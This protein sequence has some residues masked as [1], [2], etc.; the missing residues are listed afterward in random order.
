MKKLLDNLEQPEP[1]EDLTAERTAALRTKAV[2]MGYDAAV[3][4]AVLNDEAKKGKSS[5]ATTGK[6][7]GKGV[8]GGWV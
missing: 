2:G 7:R 1:G 3:V 8:V 6:R 5:R 4:D